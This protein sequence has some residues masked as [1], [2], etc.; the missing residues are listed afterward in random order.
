MSAGERFAGVG[1]F[2]RSDP[3][4]YREAVTIGAIRDGEEGFVKLTDAGGNQRLRVQ[5]RG[6]GEPQLTSYDRGGR[7]VRTRTLR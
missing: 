3:G 2:H 4:V 7:E 5:M 1:V 6:T